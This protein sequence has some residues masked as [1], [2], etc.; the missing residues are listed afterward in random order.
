MCF[1]YLHHCQTQLQRLGGSTGN[2]LKQLTVLDLGCIDTAVVRLM[3]PT[4][5]FSALQLLQCDG[6]IKNAKKS[7]EE[8]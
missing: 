3:A 7:S 4:S 6:C 2:N 8:G 1:I 5:D